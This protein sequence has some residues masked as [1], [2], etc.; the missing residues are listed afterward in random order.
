MNGT[1][2]TAN[3]TQVPN[4]GLTHQIRFANAARRQMGRCRIFRNNPG[5]IVSVGFVGRAGL[6]SARKL[7]LAAYHLRFLEFWTNE[8]ELYAND[9]TAHPQAAEAEAEDQ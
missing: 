1:A 2:F 6:S 4:I 5:H 8:K 3:S 9:S 7:S